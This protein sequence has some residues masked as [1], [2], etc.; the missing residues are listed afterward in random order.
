MKNV[1]FLIF[2]LFPFLCYA[3]DAPVFSATIISSYSYNN[4]A[5]GTSF[6][7][8]GNYAMLGDPGTQGGLGS[9]GR[10]DTIYAAPTPTSCIILIDIEDGAD[11]SICTLQ[12]N[13]L[14]KS[15]KWLV[16]KPYYGTT[17]PLHSSLYVPI[18]C[19]AYIFP[20]HLFLFVTDKTSSLKE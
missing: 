15:Y 13:A 12:Y 19:K 6:S 16:N 9:S 14:T 10:A 11:T 1:I 18:T 5:A 20:N 17:N 7:I 8:G 3:Q 2:A 4:F